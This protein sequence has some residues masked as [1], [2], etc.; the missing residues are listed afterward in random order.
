MKEKNVLAEVLTPIMFKLSSSC[1]P[2]K[3][4]I[5]NGFF[6]VLITQ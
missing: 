2:L 1:K 3:H 6:N 5:S 4:V